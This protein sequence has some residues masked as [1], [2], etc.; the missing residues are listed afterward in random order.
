VFVEP[1]RNQAAPRRIAA[2]AKVRLG[3][4]DPLGNGDWIGMMEANL[5]AL[6]EGLGDEKAAPTPALQP[7]K[8][9][10]R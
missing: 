1:Q 3:V 7:S 4:L 9:E 2:A 5:A 10:K 8:D 6:V